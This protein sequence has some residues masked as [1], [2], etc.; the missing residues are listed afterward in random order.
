MFLLF[1]CSNS[2]I[3]LV[4]KSG[5]M[6]HLCNKSVLKNMS[7]QE[8][9]LSTNSLIFRAKKTCEEK[10][11]LR[12]LIRT[13]VA[14]SQRSKLISLLHWRQCWCCW[15]QLRYAWATLAHCCSLSIVK[16]LVR[17]ASQIF[18]CYRD[19]VINFLT[20]ELHLYNQP[21]NL[22]FLMLQFLARASP[23]FSLGP[24]FWAP[25]IRKFA[26]DLLL[27]KTVRSR[28]LCHSVLFCSVVSF[29]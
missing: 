11:Y 21:N 25:K 3:Y 5:K 19:K 12:E 26:V 7:Q 4:H 2:L 17:F 29:V 28:S 24:H 6:S 22:V 23:E 16:T 18:F 27:L 13:H 8:I 1:W 9:A 15:V 10:Y 20:I 14:G